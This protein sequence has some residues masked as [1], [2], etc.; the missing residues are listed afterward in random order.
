MTMKNG[1]HPKIQLREFID[2]PVWI[3]CLIPLRH[4]RFN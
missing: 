3:K 1:F 4:V 2:P